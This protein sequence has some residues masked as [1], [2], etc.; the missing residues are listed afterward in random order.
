MEVSKQIEVLPDHARFAPEGEVSMAELVA[1]VTEAIRFCREQKIPR[2]LV[3]LSRLTGF[4]PQQLQER[5]WAVREW[6]QEAAGAVV[7]AVVA[8]EVIVDPQRFGEVV[9]ANVGLRAFI[10]SDKTEALSW[11]LAQE[12]F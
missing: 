9:A 5:Y 2:L 7:I 12:V 3:D 8:P 11:L 10:S 6:A 4:R 1:L